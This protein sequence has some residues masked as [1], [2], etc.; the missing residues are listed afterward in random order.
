MASSTAIGRSRP[1]SIGLR[2]DSGVAG[3]G[4]DGELS[5]SPELV[6]LVPYWVIPPLRSRYKEAT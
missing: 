4:V 1:G 5:G 2:S 6:V 3:K